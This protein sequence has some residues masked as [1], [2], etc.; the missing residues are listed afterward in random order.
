MKKLALLYLV[1]GI[2]TGCATTTS[3]DS[4]NEEVA[5]TNTPLIGE[6]IPMEFP[7][8]EFAQLR[9]LAGSQTLT[10]ANKLADE[11]GI[12]FVEWT[13]E[14]NPYEY[15]QLRSKRIN[16][17]FSDPQSAFLELFDRSGLLP[18][19]DEKNNA[20]TI[21]PFSLN[22][23]LQQ[24]HIFTPKFDRSEAQR[25]EIEKANDLELVK[26]QGALEYHYY[27]DFSV[28]DTIDAWAN[29]ANF[30]GVVWYFK[31]TAHENF[32][33]QKIPK[34]DFVVGGTPMSVITKFIN[35]ELIRQN[36]H[37]TVTAVHEVTTNKLILHPFSKNEVVR[38]FDVEATT[39]R[40]NLA[41]IASFYG[42]TLEYKAKDYQIFTPY[43][44]VLTQYAKSSMETVI[45]QYPLDIE[46]IDSTKRI[47]VRGRKA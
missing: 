29:H 13:Q 27:K 33:L 7:T 42:Y 30:D 6:S 34:T 46:V 37:V 45:Q 28:K 43:T 5:N 41:R 24:P 12:E 8:V 47:I 25:K 11:L 36:S 14:L 18:I 22:E 15:Q 4:K 21:Y 38:S 1:G 44:T 3:T 19:Y 9:V 35:E 39:T 23:R 20:V 2:L 31:D 32:L 10:A 40:L 16:L 17:N 26:K